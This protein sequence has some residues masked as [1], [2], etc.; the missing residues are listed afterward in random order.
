MNFQHV[1][2]SCLL[3]NV[4]KCQHF[5]DNT[6]AV[7]R[8]NSR[9]VQQVWNNNHG[10][11]SSDEADSPTGVNTGH[12]GS[13]AG[14]NTGRL[15]DCLQQH[16][17]TVGE[18]N[19]PQQG[20]SDY[21]HLVGVDSDDHRDVVNNLV[22]G[23]NILNGL[24]GS[25]NMP[26]FDKLVGN[27][28]PI[29]AAF[30]HLYH[31]SE[32]RNLTNNLEEVIGLLSAGFAVSRHVTGNK[33]AD[34]FSESGGNIADPT[35][36]AYRLVLF[37]NRACIPTSM[38]PDAPTGIPRYFQHAQLEQWVHVELQHPNHVDGRHQH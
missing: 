13:A 30:Q 12:S 33:A 7:F 14:S 19:S 36:G 11:N 28:S 9:S 29:Q 2:C 6:E 35:G 32:L 24:H 26:R 21:Q 22:E 37:C 1:L 8:L 4:W 31:M 27:I 25:C 18:S 16:E 17:W 34:S 10:G 3:K 38:A 5:V 15:R 23:A 20:G